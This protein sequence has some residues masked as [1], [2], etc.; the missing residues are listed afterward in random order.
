M[1]MRDLNLDASTFEQRGRFVLPRAS[2]ELTAPKQAQTVSKGGAMSD[3]HRGT[4]YGANDEPGD[5]VEAHGNRAGLNDEAGD[6]VE[7][8]GNR[9]G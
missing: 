1:R 7:G 8:H 3:D 4:H 2:R 5:E 6:E 9:V